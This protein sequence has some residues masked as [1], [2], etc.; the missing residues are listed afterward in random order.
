MCPLPPLPAFRIDNCSIVN[1]HK[2]CPTCQEEGS[3]F[4]RNS[5][6]L[7]TMLTS[8]SVMS[9]T[10]D[11]AFSTVSVLDMFDR[12]WSSIASKLGRQRNVEQEEGC[13]KDTPNDLPRPC[14]GLATKPLTRPSASDSGR[15][16]SL[17]LGTTSLLSL[18][19][20][21]GPGPRAEESVKWPDRPARSSMCFIGLE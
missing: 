15:K 19:V 13:N 3:R 8:P 11:S 14:S 17:A 6:V 10:S 1:Y 20:P 16:I 12:L 4:K 5:P 2:C 9:R 18:D 7:S 21:G